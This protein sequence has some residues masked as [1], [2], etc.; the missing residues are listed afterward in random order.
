VATD[1]RPRVE[2]VVE[3]VMKDR[4]VPG[5]VIAVARGDGPPEYLVIGADG[6]GRPLSEDSLFPIASVTKLATALAILRLADRGALAI[7]DPL[8]RHLPDAAAARDGVTL[9]TLLSHS[10][11]LPDDVDPEL[12]PYTPTLDWSVLSRACL[13]TP[14]VAPPGT[15]VRYSNVDLGLLGLVIERLA[16]QPYPAAVADLVLEPLGMEGYIGDEP[17]RPPAW[18]AGDL[19]E[20][21]GTE[22]DPCNSPF[23]RTL[24]MPWSSLVTTAAGALAL[25]RAF[26]G[27]PSGFLSPDLSVEATRD[28]TGGLPGTMIF[29]D[30]PRCPW[31]LGAE[32]RGDKAPHW[33][34]AEASPATFGHIGANGCSAWADPAAGIAWAM[35]GPRFM[36]DWWQD[37]PAIGSAILTAPAATGGRAGTAR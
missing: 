31:G 21:T 36:V 6:A 5:F 32:L 13:A 3:E 14:P 30:W 8:D 7:D 27:E 29:L 23:S 9:R 18:I 25:V 20:H 16:G 17:P 19:G 33:T 34:P 37:W 12:A 1:W 11:G 28:Q 15:V 35:C 4:A 10:A 26:A 24:A 2:S 22:L